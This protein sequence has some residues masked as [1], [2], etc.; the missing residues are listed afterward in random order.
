MIIIDHINLPTGCLVETSCAN[1]A[2]I[3]KAPNAV[4]FI[5]GVFINKDGEPRPLMTRAIAAEII[6]QPLK[7]PD[8]N[9]VDDPGQISPET[10][11]MIRDGLK[12][13]G[14]WNQK[15]I[16]QLYGILNWLIANRDKLP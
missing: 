13:I 9:Q 4:L 5:A 1:D 12:L 6:K 7:I 3:G 11:H 2:L 16:G 14:T 15:D 10:L 8:V